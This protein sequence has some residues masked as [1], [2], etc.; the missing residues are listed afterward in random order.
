MEDF[1]VAAMEALKEVLTAVDGT[2][3]NELREIIDQAL[4]TVLGI[5]EV[6]NN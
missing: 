3:A 2:V 6:W 1:I 5:M 4:A